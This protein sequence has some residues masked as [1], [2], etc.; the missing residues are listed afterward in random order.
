MFIRYCKLTRYITGIF[1]VSHKI[2]QKIR[3]RKY[4]RITHLLLRYSIGIDN[5]A[6][7]DDMYLH[8]SLPDVR[9]AYY[10]L[11]YVTILCTN[12][13]RWMGRGGG[14]GVGIVPTISILNWRHLCYLIAL[15]PLHVCRVQSVANNFCSN[16]YINFPLFLTVYFMLGN[17]VSGYMS[18]TVTKS[19]NQWTFFT[20]IGIK[21]NFRTT[22]WHICD[23]TFTNF[24]T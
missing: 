24:L 15:F 17:H 22:Y 5:Y 1:N 20:G 18:N 10:S 13:C 7:K 2:Q 16:Y 9:T 21:P 8:V 6:W 4:R 19:Q 14:G 11:R 12:G 3:Y 23:W